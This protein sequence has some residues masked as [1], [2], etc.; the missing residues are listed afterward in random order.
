MAKSYKKSF[1]TIQ[2]SNLI[3]LHM[4][5]LLYLTV[6]FVGCTLFGTDGISIGAALY[7]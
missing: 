6:V 2:I 7:L 1:L 3:P 4:I 5:I